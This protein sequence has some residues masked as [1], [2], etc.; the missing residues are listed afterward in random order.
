LD[1]L[2]DDSK[3][4]DIIAEIYFKQQVEEGLMQLDEGKGISHDEVKKRLGKWLN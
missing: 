4:E 2:P 3:Y 1:K